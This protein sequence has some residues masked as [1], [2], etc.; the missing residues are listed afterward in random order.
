MQIQIHRRIPASS[1]WNRWG[2]PRPRSFAF[3]SFCSICANFGGYRWLPWP[4]VPPRPIAIFFHTPPTFVSDGSMWETEKLRL[5]DGAAFADG[6]DNSFDRNNY[7]GTQDELLHSKMMRELT[8]NRMQAFATNQ[9]KLDK[10]GNPLPVD[11]QVFSSPKSS[12]YTVEARSANPAFTSAYLDALM[13]VVSGV[14]QKCP[15]RSFRRHAG[16]HF[17]TGSAAGTGYEG[18]AGGL[19]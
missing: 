7:L 1:R 3:K 5:P 9:I 16:L 13:A 18:G 2:P 12:V 4:L 15:A 14:S 17:R 8:L 19:E 6:Q 10:D 11:I